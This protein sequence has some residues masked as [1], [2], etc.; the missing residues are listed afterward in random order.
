MPTRKS[1]AKS[2]ARATSKIKGHAGSEKAVGTT[3]S[4]PSHPA[5][6]PTEMADHA[7]EQQTLVESMPFN[8]TKAAEYDARFAAAPPEGAHEPMPSPTTGAGTLSEK[9]ESAKTGAATLEPQSLDG[10]L[11][12]R[13]VNSA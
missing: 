4:G 10:S 8:S 7:A 11:E 2:P 9:H 5:A 3:T 6:G 13:R 12:S 1:R